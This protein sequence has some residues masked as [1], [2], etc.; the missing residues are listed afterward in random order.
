MK[1]L[2]SLALILAFGG[3]AAFAEE[4]AKCNSF[5]QPLNMKDEVPGLNLGNT[6]L[7]YEGE[8]KLI[9]GHEPAKKAEELKNIGVTDVV[10][11]KT[12]NKNEVTNEIAALEGLGLAED[13]IHH[14][15]MPW[16]DIKDDGACR[17]TVAALNLLLGI[18]RT[19]GAVGYFHCSAGQ[20]RTGLLAG[21]FRMT[22][23]GWSAEKAF[24]SEMCNH[25]YGFG[26]VKRPANVSSAVETG[27]TPIFLQ[28]ASQ[29]EGGGFALTSNLDPNLCAAK[30]K[31]ELDAAKF[32]CK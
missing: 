12:Q 27:L 3:A 28:L 4:K 14:V 22:A 26:D 21:L 29:I 9:R 17:Q 16:R 6:H 18:G 10:I 13:R 32:K 7:V 15:E 11:F 8:G 24:Y 2:G 1:R 5:L 25:G 30:P 20:D 31:A 23:E 19:P